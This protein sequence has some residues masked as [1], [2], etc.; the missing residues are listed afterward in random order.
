MTPRLRSG[1][2]AL[3]IWRRTDAEEFERA[4]S[5]EQRAVADAIDALATQR[6]DALAPRVQRVRRRRRHELGHRARVAS[7]QK[8]LV[9]ELAGTSTEAG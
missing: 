5:S 8:K 9:P 1:N 4:A 3:E 2:G 6:G 7:E